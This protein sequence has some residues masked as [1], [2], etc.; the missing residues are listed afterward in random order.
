MTPTLIKQNTHVISVPEAATMLGISSSKMYEV[1]RIQGF[2]A[3][4]VGRRILVNRKKF[5]EWI[6]KM[7]EEGWYLA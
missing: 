5:E 4:R 1:V 3:I 7:T 2:P 6:D